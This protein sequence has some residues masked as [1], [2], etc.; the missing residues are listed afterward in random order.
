MRSMR[1]RI[2][3]EKSDEGYLIYNAETT[4]NTMPTEANLKQ[5]S[6][7]VSSVP[8]RDG[9]SAVELDSCIKLNEF[10][11][12]PDFFANYVSILHGECTEWVL[13]VVQINSIGITLAFFNRTTGREENL[14]IK[15]PDLMKVKFEVDRADGGVDTYLV[16][17]LADDTASGGM[18]Y[19]RVTEHDAY[20][21]REICFTP[22]VESEPA[23]SQ[24]GRPYAYV[25]EYR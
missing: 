19:L 3:L 21:K 16:E 10:D 17:M 1:Y 4:W 15:C 5:A 9:W 22:P 11:I 18:H 7:R 8:I 6:I 24:S 13:A 23:M 14:Y 20:G 12:S 25:T 2:E